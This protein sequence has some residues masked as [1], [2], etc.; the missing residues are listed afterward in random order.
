MISKD[1]FIGL[2]PVVLWKHFAE[3]VSIPRPGGQEDAI[4]EWLANWADKNNFLHRRDNAGN[5]CIY[6]P[7]SKGLDNSRT[8]ALQTHLDMVCISAEKSSSDPGSGKIDVIRDGDWIVAPESTLGADNGIG[9]TA[10]MALAESNDLLHGPLELLFTVEEETTFKGAI[11]L[12]PSMIMADVMLNLDAESGELIIGSAGGIESVIR[13]PVPTKPIPEDWTVFNISLTGLCGGHSGIDIEKNRLNGIKG[14]VWLI[15]KIKDEVPICLCEISG[16]DAYNAIPIHSE[17]IISIPPTEIHKFEEIIAS[18]SEDLARQFSHTDPDLTLSKTIIDNLGIRC[19]SDELC[20]RLVDLL[21]TIPSGVIAMEQTS[22]HLVETSNNLG[23]LEVRDNT[24]GIVCFTRS[25][26]WD[27]QEQ[28]AASI[29][30]ASRLA[31]AEF[32]PDPNKTP[33]WRIPYHSSLLIIAQASYRDLF[34]REPPLATIHGGLEC[35]TI[36]EHFPELDV[37]SLGPVIQNAHKP[38]ERVSISSTAEF[39]ELLSEIIKRLSS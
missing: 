27:A 22:P 11:E 23:V 2:E 6:V 33:P 34:Q 24:L 9:I 30:S 25:S 13:W 8:I 15:Q 29:E 35:G 10:V 21:S 4:K 37:I 19:W 1:P 39:Y 7:A 14:I 5:I 31:G 26:V 38:G 20:N 28:V 18:T 32:I 3:I 36:Q 16:G 17:T 12:D